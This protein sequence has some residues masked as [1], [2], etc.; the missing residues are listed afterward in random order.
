MDNIEVEYVFND[1]VDTTLNDILIYILNL[2]I[3]VVDFE[4][5]T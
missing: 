1:N 5:E 2:K 4:N 3:R